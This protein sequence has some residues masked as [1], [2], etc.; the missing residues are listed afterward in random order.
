MGFVRKF[1]N[2]G[3][4]ELE[5]EP[6]DGKYWL[7]GVGGPD[8]VLGLIHSA[9]DSGMNHPLEKA[10]INH[11]HEKAGTTYIWLLEQLLAFSVEN[12]RRSGL[13]VVFHRSVDL[14]CKLG[15]P[16]EGSGVIRYLQ[17]RT[18]ES[19]ASLS[20]ETDGYGLGKLVNCLESFVAH[21]GW[22][23]HDDDILSSWLEMRDIGWTDPTGWT[24]PIGLTAKY[25]EVYP[26]LKA[27]FDEIESRMPSF[28]R[29]QNINQNVPAPQWGFGM[30]GQSGQAGVYQ[31]WFPGGPTNQH[32]GQFSQATAPPQIGQINSSGIPGSE[33]VVMV[34]SV[35]EGGTG[36]QQE[37]PQFGNPSSES[38]K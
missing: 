8:T 10:G 25:K 1:N 29:T 27:A 5:F 17:Q 7:H 6:A 32:V 34:G 30:H 23:S 20:F 21:D 3:R 36:Y 14:L 26:R 22:P 37:Q 16:Y 31:P 4:F 19:L 18:G 11:S 2:V 33:G 24:D 13:E 9:F 12:R 38:A 28:K 35:P 15:P